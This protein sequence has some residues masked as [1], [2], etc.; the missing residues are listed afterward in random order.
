MVR[1]MKTTTY[2]ELDE[3]ESASSCTATSLEEVAAL[4]V[5]DG[6]RFG[7]FGGQYVAETLMPAIAELEV[8]WREA[9]GDGGYWAEVEDLLVNYVGRPSL[10]YHA[11]RLSAEVGAQV[12]LKREDLNH[13]GAHKIN[14]CIGQAVLARRMGKRR[15]IAETGAGQHGV[16]TATVAALFGLPCEIYMGAED[17][18]RQSLNVE[19][20]R[21]LGAKVHPVESGTRTLKDAMNEALRDW[22]SNV[23]DTFYLIGSVAGPHPY[24]WMVRDLQSVIGREARVQIL[25]ATG[26]LPDA[27]VACVGGGSN[28]AGLFAP[29]AG[30][31]GVRLVGVEAAGEGI[32][33][34]RHAAT[35]GAGRVGVLHGSKSYV[36]AHDDGQIAHAHSI[37]AGLDYPGVGPEHA[38]WKDS[39]R[40]IYVSRTDDEAL[41]GLERL[42]RTEGILCA[43]ETAHAIAALGEVARLVGPD[44]TIIVGLSGRGDKDMVTVAQRRAT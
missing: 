23:G 26:R 37:S 22:V 42:A 12:Y 40:A 41:A 7:A 16:A 27:C 44:G 33:T 31:A 25:S 30:D 15:L 17:V 6:G 43:L 10:L 29:F 20:M 5:P 3:A 39:G 11:R 14:N 35:L 19:R 36:L 28:A 9:R 38:A 13:T 2:V 4:P 24:P 8:A 18:V 21:L 34:G 32:A 1:E